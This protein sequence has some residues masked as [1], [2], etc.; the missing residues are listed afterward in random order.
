MN[1]DVIKNLVHF[2]LRFNCT[3][4]HIPVIKIS[5]RAKFQSQRTARIQFFFFRHKH[6]T[7]KDQGKA[8]FRHSY[9]TSSKRLL[10]AAQ[11]SSVTFS[12]SGCLTSYPA[13]TSSL[14]R[15]RIPNL[16][17][18]T[19]RWNK[20]ILKVTKKKSSFNRRKPQENECNKCIKMLNKAFF[21]RF[22]Q[23]KQGMPAY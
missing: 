6:H 10:M 12:L 7:K 22:S 5:I 16:T 14:Q 2:L 4:Y 15:S 8:D 11:W 20:L 19:N 23:K 9:L 21:L 3:I 18:R 1:P 13:S 17:G